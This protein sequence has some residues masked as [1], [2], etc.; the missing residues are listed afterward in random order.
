MIRRLPVLAFLGTAALT[1]AFVN[2]PAQAE[3]VCT[4]IMK[5]DDASV[6]VEEGDCDMREAPASTFKLPLAVAGYDAQILKSPDS[7]AVDYDPAKH[8]G[9]LESWKT[10]VTPRTWL[11]DSVVWYSWTVTQPMGLERVETYLDRFDY[12]NKDM[13]GSPGKDDGLTHAWLGTSLKISPREQALFLSR[14]VMR[15]LPVKVFSQELAIETTAAYEA[16]GELGVKG[17]T[18]L[19]YALD[20]AGAVDRSRQIGWFV[21]WT[22]TATTPVV[23]VRLI[24]DQ[25][26]TPGYASTRA[27]DTLLA[28]LPGYLQQLP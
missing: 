7:P 26:A 15:A 9:W 25:E 14:L 21:G 20:A 27:R 18:G 19:T 12:G 8:V 4:L 23:F 2:S 6:L 22:E 24:K 16:T 10:T 5:A 17:K 28:D 11:R 1:M 3:T 13:S